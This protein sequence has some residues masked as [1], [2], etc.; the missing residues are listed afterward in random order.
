MADEG[1]LAADVLRLSDRMR[2]KALRLQKMVSTRTPFGKDS[3][4]LRGASLWSICG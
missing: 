3:T 4:W 2:N 1:E